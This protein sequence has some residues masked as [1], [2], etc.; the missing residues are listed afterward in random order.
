M[1][2][3]KHTATPASPGARYHHQPAALPY[4]LCAA[5][6]RPMRWRRR[7]AKNWDEVRYCSDACRR[8]KGPRG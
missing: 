7:W 5:C 1:P 4:K 2:N 6:G 8:L 3:K